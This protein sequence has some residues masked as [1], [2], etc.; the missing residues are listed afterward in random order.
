LI[1]RPGCEFT[2]ADMCEA[3]ADTRVRCQATGDSLAA[4]APHAGY[5]ARVDPDAT[6][7]W[8]GPAPEPEPYYLEPEIS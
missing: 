6:V 2:E 3:P 8:P 1:D 7:Q 5:L 4:C